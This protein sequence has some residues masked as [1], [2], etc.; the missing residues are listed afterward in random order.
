MAGVIK[1]RYE[2]H[3]G[4]G[5]LSQKLATGLEGKEQSQGPQSLGKDLPESRPNP[6]G[7]CF[8]TTFCPF[9]RS[10]GKI[11]TATENHPED[12][13]TEGKSSRI[14]KIW[15]KSSLFFI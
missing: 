11:E 7:L 8:K 14:W 12:C 9:Q 1:F 3:P 15:T 6:D 5:Y 4:M 2:Q 13:L 10:D